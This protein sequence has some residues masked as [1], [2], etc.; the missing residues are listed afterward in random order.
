MQEGSGPDAAT[1]APRRLARTQQ[2]RDR[3][4]HLRL[5]TDELDQLAIAARAEGVSVATYAAT[6]ALGLAAG[7]HVPIPTSGSERWHALVAARLEAQ[8]IR[9]Q[10]S[11]LVKQLAS[12]EH[13]APDQLGALIAAAA[14]AVTRLDRAAISF[15]PNR[16]RER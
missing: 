9:D 4:V 11:Q 12:S 3:Q 15:H 13:E 6:A 14:A 16:Q 8:R 5:S 2:R 7:Q 10:L 1:V